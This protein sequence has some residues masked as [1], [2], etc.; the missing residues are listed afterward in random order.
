[1]RE[2]SNLLM[3]P[4]QAK[5][6]DKKHG[7][8]RSAAEQNPR[9]PFQIG[10]DACDQL[11]FPKVTLLIFSVFIL[12]VVSNASGAIHL[13]SKTPCNHYSWILLILT[14]VIDTEKL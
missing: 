3:R 14:Y 11:P 12:V 2:G 9:L 4:W 8:D 10:R 5:D 13:Q 1:V 6:D 7:R